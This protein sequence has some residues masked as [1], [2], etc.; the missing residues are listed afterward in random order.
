[1]VVFPGGFGTLDELFETL[2]LLQTRKIEPLPVILVGESY[3]RKAFD[4][5]F[6]LQ[7][8]VIDPQDRDL[9]WYAESAREIW[10]GICQ[11]HRDTGNVLH[12]DV[13]SAN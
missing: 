12:A 5:D 2:T 6:L 3:W 4:P 1:L 10:D 9:F 11:W 13:Q 8:G 7:E